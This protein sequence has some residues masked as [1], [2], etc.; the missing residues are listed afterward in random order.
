MVSG[1]VAGL[2]IAP[3]DRRRP[4]GR[5]TIRNPRGVFIQR[6]RGD[7]E[8]RAGRCR[9][10]D[11]H[12]GQ[13]VRPRRQPVPAVQVD[14][15]EDRLDE[16]REALDRERQAD[17][18]RRTGPSGRARACP[19][20]T[21]GSCRR[22]RRPRTARPSPWPSGGPAAEIGVG[23]RRCAGRATRRTAPARACPR[24]GRR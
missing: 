10:D 6:V 1:P 12:A 23:R 8:E 7:H 16:E 18:P 4:P 21:T 19:S 9:P 24:R 20:R 13:Q 5:S 3:T 2:N 14:A 22:P 17:R 11:R 15:E